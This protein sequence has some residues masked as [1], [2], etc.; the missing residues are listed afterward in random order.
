MEGRCIGR[1]DVLL[2]DELDL[3]G[4]LLSQTK[5]EEVRR[6]TISDSRKN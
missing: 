5:S 4:E 3:P 6:K 1:R 2:D